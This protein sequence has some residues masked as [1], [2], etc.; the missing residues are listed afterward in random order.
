MSRDQ[1]GV[2]DLNEPI[3]RVRPGVDVIDPSGVLIPSAARATRYARILQVQTSS[4]FDGDYRSFQLSALKRMANRWSGR[5]AYTLQE[6]HYVGLGN[7]DARRVWL[8]QD[9]RADYGRFASDRRHVLAV[10]GT[11]NPWQSLNVATV[12]SAISG[13][14][15]NEIVGRDVNGDLDVNDRPVRGVDDALFPIRS[16]VDSQGR[17]V[18]NGLEGP[19][20]FLVDVSFRYSVPFSNGL[21]SLDLFYDIFNLLNRENLV[22]PTGNRASQTFMVPT[23]AQFPRQMQFGIRVR[24]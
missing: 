17:A 2:I 4:A 22:A 23:A 7:P 8:D 18:I 15:I 24:F 1:L 11:V 20:S 3:D 12:V 16:A 14:P 9:P 10:S 21:E 6:S 13:A 5:V 19:G